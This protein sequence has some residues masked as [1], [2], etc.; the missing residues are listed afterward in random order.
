MWS[1]PVHP[2]QLYAS[3][4]GL[5]LFVWFASWRSMRPGSR[6]CAFVASYGV[7]RFFMEWLRGDFR[8]V[9]GPFSLPQVFS[10]LFVV[11]G[12]GVWLRFVQGTHAAVRCSV[13]VAEEIQLPFES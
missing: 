12:L 9:L 8:A 1:L 3:V 5:G 4:L 7:A 2:V 10:F 13:A 11:A 6:F